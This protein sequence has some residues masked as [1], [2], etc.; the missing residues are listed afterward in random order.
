M[1]ST[2]L[3]RRGLLG[4]I[5]GLPIF[6]RSAEPGPPSFELV[7]QP[8]VGQGMR[9]LFERRTVR[10]GTVLQWYRVP[11][12]IQ[13]DEASPDGTLLRWAQG[14]GTVLGADP[15]LR[16]LLESGLAVM[17]GVPLAVRLDAR[18]QVQ[19]L[20]NVAEVRRLCLDMVDRM[21]ASLASDEATRAFVD[22]LLPAMKAGFATEP[23]VAAASLREPQILLSAMGRRFGADEPVEFR[24]AL[25]NPFGGPAMPAIARFSVHGVDKRAQRAK[26]GWLMV[27]DPA[28]TTAAARSAVED[29]ATL[30]AAAGAAA[31]VTAALPPVA[32]EE[33]G[34]FV[35]DTQTAWPIAVTHTRRVTA[36]AHAQVDTSTFTRDGA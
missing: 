13:V 19:S 17:N 8:R 33:R 1:S 2:S 14:A 10:S 18:G 15:Q 34:D 5:M 32:L 30:A 3:K 7:P 11:L 26:L 20:D 12:H 25:G 6:G 9:L 21:I 31:P 4:L 36:G 23:L 29:V 27:S 22:T 28:A 16:P 35:V 24:T